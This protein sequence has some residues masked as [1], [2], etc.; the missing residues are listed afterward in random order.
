MPRPSS[1]SLGAGMLSLARTALESDDFPSRVQ[2]QLDALSR[3]YGVT[4]IGVELP[5]LEH[6]IVVALSRSQAPVRLHVDVGSR[7]PP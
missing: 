5:N 1:Y 6:M 4:A 7:F 3:R 2:P